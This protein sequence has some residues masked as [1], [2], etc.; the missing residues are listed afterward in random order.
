MH[1][2]EPWSASNAPDGSGIPG[3]NI[4]GPNHYAV[5]SMMD[6]GPA[7]KLNPPN[8]RRTI[9]CVNALAG[10][11]PEAVV[12]LIKTANVWREASCDCDRD[13]RDDHQCSPGCATW[14]ADNALCKAIDAIKGGKP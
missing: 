5:C 12:R 11:N 8:A 7:T 6:I 9:A 10:L 14:K 1:T 2:P 13:D 4:F 3:W